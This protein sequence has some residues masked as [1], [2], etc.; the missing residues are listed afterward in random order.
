MTVISSI[1]KFGGTV[2]FNGNGVGGCCVCG[3]RGVPTFINGERSTWC[4]I[5]PR[6]SHPPVARRRPDLKGKQRKAQKAA[7]KRNRR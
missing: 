1:P 5:C 2:D 6:S 4:P 3:W 7:R